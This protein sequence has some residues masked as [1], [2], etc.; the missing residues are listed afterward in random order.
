LGEG[1]SLGVS[2]YEAREIIDRAAAV[3][4]RSNGQIA[5]WRQMLTEEPTISNRAAG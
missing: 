1:E 4:L 3:A 2:G 5:E